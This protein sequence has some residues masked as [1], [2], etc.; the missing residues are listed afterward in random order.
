MIPIRYNLRSLMVRRVTSAMTAMGVALVV[1]ILFILF[2]FIGGLQRTLLMAGGTGNWIV[3]SKGA[4]AEGASVIGHEALNL[5]RVRP[6][7][8]TDDSGAP[9]ISPELIAGLN[10]APDK[11][12]RQFTYL[13]GVRPIAYE[14]HRNLRLVNGHWPIRG[15]SEWVIGQKLA[16]RFP[17]LAPGTTF[18]YGRRT[19]SIA[20]VF[21]DR[22]SA[23][24]SEVWT[25]FD[26]LNEDAQ[27]KESRCNSVRLV[28]RPGMA[29]SFKRALAKDPRLPL[30][31]VTEADFYAD[32]AKFADNLRSLG[33]VV[34]ITL[35]IGAVFGGMNTMYA[36]V[37][38]RG[39]ELSV[40]RALGFDRGSVLLS[41]VLESLIIGL[42]GGAAGEAL[43]LA[44][45]YAIGLNSRQMNVGTFLFS[46]RPNATA[47]AAG[48]AMAAIIGVL[49]GLMPAWRAARIGV[50][51]SLREA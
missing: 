31:A 44:I 11:R 40:L 37:A 43:A 18:H 3:L 17:S 25:D 5:L 27:I 38:R 46:Y 1:M 48:I 12:R 41:F 42:A 19:W 33:L 13:R 21:S 47:A 4:P 45:G 6:E 2:G 20:G 30:D 14:V 51:D 50:I 49:G 28:M 10:I 24:E 7:I 16:A 15:H 36:A 32:Q 8:A 34:A 35:A 29:A 39:L 22:D 23:R 26:D 9:L